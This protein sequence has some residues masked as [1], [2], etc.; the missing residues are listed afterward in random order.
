VTAS[1]KIT[2]A[3]LTVFLF[4]GIVE[5][6]AH[7]YW[8]QLKKRVFAD[9]TE[10]SR[11]VLRNDAINFMKVVHPVYGYVLKPGQY[12]Q[13][14]YVNGQG[15]MQRDIV[16]LERKAGAL[17]VIAMGESTTQGHDVDEGNYPVYLRRIFQRYS[18]TSTGV[19]V[20]N[21]GVSGWVSDQVMLLAERELAAYRP[22]IVILYVGWNDFQSYDPFASPPIQSYFTQ[23]YGGTRMVLEKSGLK[24]LILFSAAYSAL[25][26]TTGD[27]HAGT[28]AAKNR[29]EIYRFYLENIERTIQAYRREN[30]GVVIAV[31]TLASRWPQG[32]RQQF[33][34]R[35]GHVWW[36]ETRKLGPNDAAASLETFNEL[37]REF[38][39]SYGVL[40]I[41][42]ASVFENLDREA[43]FWDFAH[44]HPEG[45]ELL[46]EVLYE[47]L[48][49]NKV[50]DGNQSPR[51]E[52]L[53]HKYQ[54]PAATLLRQG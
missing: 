5:G 40:L 26:G 4:I 17:R 44:M 18:N 31:C 38:T 37:I 25:I 41:D 36:M 49:R 20:I 46:A 22:D 11:E 53:I 42:I 32:K 10:K 24:S 7:L 13:G 21:A 54:L 45:Y 16:P 6:A 30:Q 8:W 14:L 52:E 2:F 3:L 12:S 43:L 47:T 29:N 35:N 33:D 23:A 39:R 48:R 15:F 1:R 27:R 51:R 28:S 34:E 50:I 19:E 9:V